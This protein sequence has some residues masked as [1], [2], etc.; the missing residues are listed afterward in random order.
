VL[1]LVAT[2]GKILTGILLLFVYS[3]GFAVPMLIA[4]YASQFFRTRL[5]KIGKFPV[6][7]NI[8]SGLLLVALGL[9][10]V[11]RGMIGFGF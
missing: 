1:A 11:F 8:A 4:G 6:V 3:L 2:Q 9:F 10:I 5:R 7:V